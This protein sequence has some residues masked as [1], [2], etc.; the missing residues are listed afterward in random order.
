M[1][2]RVIARV[3]MILC[4]STASGVKIVPSLHMFEVRKQSAGSRLHASG[5]WP[6]TELAGKLAQGGIKTRDDLADL[7]VDDLVEISGIDVERAKALIMK[8]R[9]HWFAQEESNK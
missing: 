8:A 7:A 3:R 6:D 2:C 4:T 5:V 9:E 1:Q